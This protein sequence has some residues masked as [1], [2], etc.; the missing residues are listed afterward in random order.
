MKKLITNKIHKMKILT[1]NNNIQI[2][3]NKNTN[4]MQHQ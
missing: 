1:I 4:R 3:K 2:I